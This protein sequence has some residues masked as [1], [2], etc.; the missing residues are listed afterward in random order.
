MITGPV[1][2]VEVFSTGPKL[3]FWEFLLAWGHRFT[4]SVE[5]CL[6]IWTKV[7]TL[8]GLSPSKK[9]H[10]AQ[11][12]TYSRHVSNHAEDNDYIRWEDRTSELLPYKIITYNMI[13]II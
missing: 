12:P 4:L 11:Q 8:E 2:P 10:L 9:T 5:P 13:L 3:V 6:V 7:I 1:G